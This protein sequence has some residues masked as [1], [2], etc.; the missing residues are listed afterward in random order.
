VRAPARRCVQRPVLTRAH[1]EARNLPHAAQLFDAAARIGGMGALEAYYQLGVLQ[2]GSYRALAARAAAAPAAST[3]NANTNIDAACAS[4][5]SFFKA[6]AERGAWDGDALLQGADDAW[7]E[8]T[9]RGKE[10]A[11]GLWALASEMGYEPAQ[12][13]LAFVLD[14]GARCS[15][16]RRGRG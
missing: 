5:V 3:P 13:N 16:R 4:A 2:L 6:A 15:E 7:A 14:Q 8:G 11:M 10:R 9:P 1:T 12:N